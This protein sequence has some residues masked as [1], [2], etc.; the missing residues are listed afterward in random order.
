MCA[1]LDDFF[2]KNSIEK[3]FGLMKKGQGLFE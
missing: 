1:V 2:Q 3:R